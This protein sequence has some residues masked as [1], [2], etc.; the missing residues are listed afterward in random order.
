[1]HTGL[2]LWG[3]HSQA[4]FYFQVWDTKGRAFIVWKGHIPE[5]FKYK[6]VCNNRI[7]TEM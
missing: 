7:E 1:M 4:W 3:V 5:H 2:L 6:N